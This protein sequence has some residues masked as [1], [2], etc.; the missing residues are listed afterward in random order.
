MVARLAAP[1]QR[2]ADRVHRDA[3]LEDGDQGQGQ[4]EEEGD[5]GHGHRH[6]GRQLLLRQW[7]PLDPGRRRPPAAQRPHAQLPRRRH[8][9]GLPGVRVRAQQ[10]AD[11]AG[12]APGQ[13]ARRDR[14]PRPLPLQP[15]HP[16]G[17]RSARDHDL[18][19]GAGLL[20]QGQVPEV[21]SS[22]ASWRPSTSSDNVAF[23]QNHPSIIVWSIGN[24]LSAAPRPGAGAVHQARRRHRP[25]DRPDA[26]GRPRRRGRR[27]AGCQTEYK[28][29]DVIGLNEYFGWYPGEQGQA[30][31][32]SLLADAP[33]RDPPVLSRQGDGDHRDRRR[34]QPQRPGRGARHLPVPGGAT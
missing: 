34:G 20:D 17:G 9:R 1:L 33:R 6:E 27:L 10:R 24:E 11:G 8:A 16:G 26:A 30:A 31:D 4:E 13:G 22:C 3:A 32:Q 19:R 29:L 23:N 5:D 15:V 14:D 7:Y 25:R 18:V 12:P 2:D 21:A 28:P